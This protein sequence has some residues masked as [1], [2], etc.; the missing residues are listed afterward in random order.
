MI[1]AFCFENKVAV[2]LSL[3]TLLVKIKINNKKIKK[4]KVII[5]RWEKATVTN[6]S[7][8]FDV[9]IC[10]Y[11]CCVLRQIFILT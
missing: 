6:V 3:L 4:C 11:E 9:D 1:L 2:Y 7:N 5:V 10:V 8:L